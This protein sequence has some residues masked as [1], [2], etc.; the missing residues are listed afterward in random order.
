MT[1]LIGAEW[2]WLWVGDRLRGAGV[3]TEWDKPG[4]HTPP[5]PRV[6][7]GDGEVDH[8]GYILE[9]GTEG[10]CIGWDMRGEEW[11]IWK[12][13]EYLTNMRGD[14]LIHITRW[15]SQRKALGFHE[16]PSCL[17]E[18][19]LRMV[20]LRPC[21]AHSPTLGFRKLFCGPC[22][23]PVHPARTLWCDP[24][25]W[26]DIAPCGGSVIWNSAVLFPRWCFSCYVRL[27]HRS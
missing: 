2:P 16:G 9:V 19:S 7:S 11:L 17:Q 27:L 4:T 13:L 3:E 12:T 20:S 25:C 22:S 26:G 15:C 6:C 18:G 23:V 1:Y 10:P 24:F 21:S 5:L 8:F 14:I